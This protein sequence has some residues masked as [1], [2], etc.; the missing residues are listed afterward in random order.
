M[1]KQQLT[2][3]GQ[4]TVNRLAIFHQDWPGFK[5]DLDRAMKMCDEGGDWERKNKIK[6]DEKSDCDVTSVR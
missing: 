4:P 6:V 2:T 3:P 5:A 1:P